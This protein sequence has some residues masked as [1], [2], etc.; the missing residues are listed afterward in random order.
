MITEE[1]MVSVPQAA[2]LCGVSRNTVNNWIN[3]KRLQAVRS[4]RNYA[5][6]VR[7]LLICLK[8]RGREIPSELEGD[9]FQ[10]PVFKG[11]RHCWEYWK[12]S[13]HGT[14]CKD[15]VVSSNQ[16]DICFTAR[17]SSKLYCDVGCCKCHYYKE[18]YLPRIHFIYQIV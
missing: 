16:L 11:F 9:D 6:P 15:C 18:I 3:A 14:V 7:E 4:G 8:S 2:T 1:K 13:Y 10:R 5:V 12:D 17:E